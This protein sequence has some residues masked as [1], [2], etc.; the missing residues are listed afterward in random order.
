MH[1][2]VIS[3]YCQLFVQK[4]ISNAEIEMTIIQKYYNNT[5]YPIAICYNAEL[6]ISE[7]WKDNLNTISVQA[8]LLMA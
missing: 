4:E 7:D 6:K 8:V 5:A 2:C 3:N 1:Q